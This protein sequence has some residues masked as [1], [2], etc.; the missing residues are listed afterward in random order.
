VSHLVDT[1]VLLWLLAEPGRVPEEVRRR[2]ADRSTE[3]MVSAVSALEIA[4]K[5]RLGR[6]PQGQMLVH[7]WSQ[8]LERIGAVELA[9]TSRHAVLAGTL[10]WDHRD[11]FD[12][13]LVAQAT[14]EQHVLVTVDRAIAAL[15]GVQLL[16]W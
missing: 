8:W 2:L 16:T 4:T 14:R 15:P 3:L 10:S 11:P 1:H 7:G 12:R 6:L 13:I 5:V 9:I